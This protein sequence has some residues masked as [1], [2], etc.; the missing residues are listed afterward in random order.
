[1]KSM[2]KKIYD[3]NLDPANLCRG[4]SKTHFTAQAKYKKY[5]A[6]FLTS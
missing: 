2:I 4:H 1:M 6:I 3:G 5:E